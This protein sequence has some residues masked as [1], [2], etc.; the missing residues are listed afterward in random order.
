[1]ILNCQTKIV[2]RAYVVECGTLPDLG[3]APIEM[4]LPTNI[5]NTPV[6]MWM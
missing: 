4:M 3:E 6:F 2:N 5:L 1:M